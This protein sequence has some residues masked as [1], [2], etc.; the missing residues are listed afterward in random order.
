ME[1]KKSC[2]LVQ[3]ALCRR[4]THRFGGGKMPEILCLRI[5]LKVRSSLF[6][7]NQ[8]LCFSWDWRVPRVFV[9]AIQAASRLSSLVREGEIRHPHNDFTPTEG[10][11]G[12]GAKEPAVLLGPLSH[13]STL[14]T[15]HKL[16]HVLHRVP[17]K[18]C[19]IELAIEILGQ[20]GETTA[21]HVPLQAHPE[22]LWG[23]GIR[24]LR[25]TALVIIRILEELVHEA[26]PGRLR[27]LALAG[28]CVP[29][30]VIRG[31]A[32][33]KTPAGLHH[34]VVILNKV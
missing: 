31:T 5:R 26:L 15:I 1:T 13:V 21:G 22:L 23:R 32:E 7:R 3:P 29:A 2:V 9:L 25:G 4:T 33:H 6:V 34:V 10:G 30:T 8:I 20:L 28:T 12:R 19:L 16:H 14:V 24:S 18:I 17:P 27:L 11:I